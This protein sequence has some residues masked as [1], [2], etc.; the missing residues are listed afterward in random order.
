MKRSL[1]IC[2]NLRQ[3]ALV[4]TARY[5]ETLAPSGLKVTMFRLLRNVSDTPGI[6]ISELATQLGLDRS[7]MGRNLRLLERRGLAQISV[8]KDERARGVVLTPAGKAALQA[9]I[10]LWNEA[11]ETMGDLIG[12]DVDHLLEMLR[13]LTDPI[14]EGPHHA[15]H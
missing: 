13:K 12:T 14:S 2:T 10:P 8:G 1:C 15:E 9:G 3:A 6:M 7:T 5:D 11:Q 4:A